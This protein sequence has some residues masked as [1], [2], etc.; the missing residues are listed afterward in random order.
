MQGRLVLPNIF[1]GFSGKKFDIIHTHSFFGPGLDALLF[2]RI[3][4]IPI[5]GTNHTIIKEFVCYSPIHN[6]LAECAILGYVKW[7]YN[8]LAFVSTPSNFLAK[9]MRE[10]G[11]QT[12]AVAVSNPIDPGFF[13]FSK[14]RETLK[15]E[16]GLSAFTVLHAGRISAE[17]GVETLFKGF[18]RFAKIVP[19]AGL[20]IVGQGVLRSVIEK[21]SRATGLEK[22]VKFLGPYLGENKRKLYEIFQASDVFV[23][24]STSESQCMSMLQAM[25][26]GIPVVGARAAALPEYITSDRGLLFAPNDSV[27]LANSLSLLESNSAL[28]EKLGVNTKSFAETLS[29]V[30]IANIWE[31]IYND[32]IKKH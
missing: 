16:L 27:E 31:K 1:R 10:N 4:N 7:Y 13:N 6:N 18:L 29:V 12:F 23:T 21:E 11:L 32:N 17:K 30:A 8:R 24:A 9:D 26:V 19:E 22:R 2:A 15:K 14:S 28:R 20:V 3:K 5:I 25:A